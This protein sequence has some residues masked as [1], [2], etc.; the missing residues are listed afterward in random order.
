MSISDRAVILLKP[1]FSERVGIRLIA[2]LSDGAVLLAPE[3]SDPVMT[4]RPEIA[5]QLAYSACV[6]AADARRQR[7]I[8]IIVEYHQR[9]I[10][11][12]H[13]LNEHRV[14]LEAQENRSLAVSPGHDRIVGAAFQL[15]IAYC[16]DVYP[17]TI[18]RSGG[19]QSEDDLIAE[20]IH[21]VVVDTSVD[22]DNY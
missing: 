3:E 4:S 15:S 5:H 13:M 22:K 11:T 17:D 2:F 21:L 12:A 14:R 6:I 1:E 16:G 7:I 20:L 18:L 9:D 8:H 19:L 10:Q